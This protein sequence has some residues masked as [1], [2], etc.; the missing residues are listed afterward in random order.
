MT[1]NIKTLTAA[2]NMAMT[3]ANDIEVTKSL[4]RVLKD[5]KVITPTQEWKVIIR[6]VNDLIISHS[7]VQT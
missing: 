7:L 5:L 6:K 1:D 3:R 4:L 2:Q